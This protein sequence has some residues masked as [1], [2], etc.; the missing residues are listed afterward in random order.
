M[1]LIYSTYSISLCRSEKWRNF[2]NLLGMLNSTRCCFITLSSFYRTF[3]EFLFCFTPQPI[4]K[5]IGIFTC[6]SVFLLD[7]YFSGTTDK[8]FHAYFYSLWHNQILR[9]GYLL[10]HII[11]IRICFWTLNNS[12][13]IFYFAVVN[14]KDRVFRDKYRGSALTNSDDCVAPT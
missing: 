4:R 7:N 10:F 8:V 13:I 2:H 11:K 5:W 1:K 14:M 9:M 6:I 12:M 3:K